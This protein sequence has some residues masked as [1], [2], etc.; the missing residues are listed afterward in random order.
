MYPVRKC[1]LK[2]RRDGSSQVLEFQVVNGDVRPLLS[3]I[4]TKVEFEFYHVD[5]V[6]QDS[7]YTPSTSKTII[8]DNSLT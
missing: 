3:A 2:C 5:S 8:D 4:M 1:K 6:T 7:L